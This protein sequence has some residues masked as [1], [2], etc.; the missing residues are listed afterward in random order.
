VA[1]VQTEQSIRFGLTLPLRNR[2]ALEALLQEQRDPSSPRYRQY[3][4]ARQFLEEYGP[5]QADYDSVVA[6]AKSQGFTVTHTYANRLLVN[7]SGSPATIN[8]TFAVQMQVHQRA[9]QTGK[10]YAP[11]VEPS[12]DNSLPILS[13]EGLSTRDLPHPMLVHA[14]T[15][16]ADTTGSG[17]SG[18]FLGS[19]IRAA[20]A[21]GVTLDGQGQTVGLVELGPYNLSDVRMYFTAVNQP[22]K[23]P[24]YNV[25]LDVD[26]IC[27]GTPSSGAAT[28][29]KKS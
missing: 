9:A 17:Q 29:A 23:V 13:V 2:A 25:L 10:Y 19:D 15:V 7:V 27:S 1:P 21:P 6:F 4:T 18:Q 26:G 24:I 12:V 5:T 8:K 11:D 3:L 14:Q 16:H 28:T 22:L 20:Y